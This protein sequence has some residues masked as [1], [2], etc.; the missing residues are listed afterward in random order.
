MLET[1]IFKT[2]SDKKNKESN[3]ITESEVVAI[4]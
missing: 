3:N 2:P 1:P 4:T